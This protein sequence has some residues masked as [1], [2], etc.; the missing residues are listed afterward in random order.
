MGSQGSNQLICRTSKYLQWPISG[1]CIS[2]DIHLLYSS[3]HYHALFYQQKKYLYN[4][5]RLPHEIP[6]ETLSHLKLESNN[7][8]RS[9]KVEKKIE[10][11][12]IIK[13]K[14]N[15][16]NQDEPKQKTIQPESTRRWCRNAKDQPKQPWPRNGAL[17]LGPPAK[18]QS[19]DDE[20]TDR[21]AAGKTAAT[22]LNP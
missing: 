13:A 21:L 15:E 20:I 17:P 18:P 1:K 14:K 7:Q 11:E 2:V 5:L 19:L 4:N 3:C 16:A 12:R 6:S 8:S 10:K 9:T 22:R